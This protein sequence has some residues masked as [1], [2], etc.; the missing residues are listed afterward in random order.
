MTNL[1]SRWRLARQPSGAE[2]TL[3]LVAHRGAPRELPEN[4]VPSFLRALERGAPSVELDTHVTADG[5]VVVHHDHAA[6]RLPIRTTS[7]ADLSR[8]DLGDGARIPK[9]SEVLDAIGDRAMVYIELKGFSVENEVLAIA[10]KHGRRFL[11]HSFDNNAIQRVRDREP[12]IRTGLLFERDT[13]NAPDV[14]RR[15]VERIR[16]DDVWPHWSLVDEPFM[17]TAQELGV[18]VISWTVNTPDMARDFA[19][20]G[21]DGVCTDDVRL[22]ANQG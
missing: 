9:L 15:A 1:G 22:L 3:E 4:T 14:M 12:S 7:W 18:R 6:Q 17:R 13:R 20:L 11:L 8:L 16:P 5:E 2:S 21:V 19:A 10:Q